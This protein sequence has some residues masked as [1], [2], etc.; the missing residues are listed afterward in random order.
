[1]LNLILLCVVNTEVESQSPGLEFEM[2]K[3]EGLFNY[4]FF[5]Q[6]FLLLLLICPVYI[7]LIS[8]RIYPG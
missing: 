8:G 6:Q 5:A 2:L 4:L 1:M 7:C 3:L